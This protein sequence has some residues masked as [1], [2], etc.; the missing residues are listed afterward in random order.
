MN[1]HIH[2][3]QATEVR[4][5]DEQN[6][7]A[8]ARDGRRCGGRRMLIKFVPWYGIDATCYH[9]GAHYGDDGEQAP[10]RAD[11]ARVRREWLAAREGQTCETT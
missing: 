1:V 10:G 3:P 6:C 8:R 2:A 4:A 11:V 9:C 7:P 5:S